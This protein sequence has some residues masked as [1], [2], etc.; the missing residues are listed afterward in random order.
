MDNFTLANAS[1]AGQGGG[2]GDSSIAFLSA[3]ICPMEIEEIFEFSI[4]FCKN[5]PKILEEPE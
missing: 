1:F 2:G 3:I 4:L 5:F